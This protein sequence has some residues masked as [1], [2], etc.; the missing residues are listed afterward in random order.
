MRHKR[1]VLYANLRLDITILFY[2]L[3][4]S[5]SRLSLQ[6]IVVALLQEK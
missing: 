6:L 3:S 1:C 2:F 5:L 4:L